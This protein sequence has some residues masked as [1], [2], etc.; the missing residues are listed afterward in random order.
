MNDLRLMI[1]GSFRKSILIEIKIVS[2]FY[3]TLQV[4]TSVYQ[5]V[6][7][8]SCLF[9]FLHHGIKKT[10]EHILH[11]WGFIVFY[12]KKLV[13]FYSL[14]RNYFILSKN[15]I[16]RYFKN[17]FYHVTLE[18]IYRILNNPVYF[19]NIVVCNERLRTLFL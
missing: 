8:N 1:K 14:Y 18:N 5:N 13:W 3:I 4:D 10:K 9:L 2:T 11:K 15:A 12:S 17:I 7:C 19:Q 16:F 6:I